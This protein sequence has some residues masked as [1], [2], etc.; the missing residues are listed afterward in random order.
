MIFIIDMNRIIIENE[1]V[2]KEGNMRSKLVTIL[3]ILF[4]SFIILPMNSFAASAAD[5]MKQANKIINQIIQSVDK[6]D[7]RSCL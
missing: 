3:L 7:I 1:N 5:E 4:I 6:G 2:H